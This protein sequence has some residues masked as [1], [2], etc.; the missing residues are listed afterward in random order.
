M[1]QTKTSAKKTTT[2][3]MRKRSAKKTSQPAARYLRYDLVN[4]GTPNTETSHYISLAKDL[5]IVNRRLMRQGKMYHVKKVTIVSSNTPSVNN[6]APDGAVSSSGG[7]VS[8]AVIPDNWVS[9]EAWKRAFRVWTEMNKTASDQ[10]AGNIQGTWADFKVWLST[11][12]RSATFPLP[13]DNG[14]DPFLAGEWVISNFV[15]PDGTT[16]DDEFTGHMLGN[17]LGAA[18]SRLSVG[19]IQSYGESRATVNQ[20]NPNVPS[21]AAGDPLVNVFDYGTTIDDVVQHLQDDNDRPPYDITTYPG[22]DTNGAKPTIVQD[23]TL[24]DGRASMAGF[25]AMLGLLEIEIKSPIAS[26][27]YSVLVELAPG[28]YR[29]IHAEVI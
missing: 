3:S 4:S 6:F 7:R 17:H 21:A 14:G 9:R 23:T 18:G 28:K 22:M 26:D 25:T 8:V 13:L 19:L 27:V 11:S 1:A 16:T 24:V 12:A 2:K 10:L 20:G 29:G 5:S 15:T